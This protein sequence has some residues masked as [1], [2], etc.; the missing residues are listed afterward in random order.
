MFRKLLLLMKAILIAVGLALLAGI[1][2]ATSYFLG[3][4]LSIAG[5][6]AIVALIVVAVYSE[7]KRMS[8]N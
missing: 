5:T 8:K 1:V 7:S 3:I 2:I 4:F 6:I